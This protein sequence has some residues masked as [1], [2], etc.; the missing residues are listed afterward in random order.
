M[1]N[2]DLNAEGGAMEVVLPSFES[3]DNGKEFMIIYIV[4]MFCREEGLRKVRTGMPF[5][6]EICLKKNGT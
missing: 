2:E 3:T 4:V 5:S 6:I 1:V